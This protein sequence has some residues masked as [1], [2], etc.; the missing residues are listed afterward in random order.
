MILTSMGKRCCQ[1]DDLQLRREW[2]RP[3]HQLIEPGLWV[4]VDYAAD[5]VGEVAVRLDAGERP[6]GRSRLV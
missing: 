4:A 1:A 3:G 2:V 5:D 6:F